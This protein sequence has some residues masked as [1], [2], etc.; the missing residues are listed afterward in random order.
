MVSPDVNVFVKT[1][2]EATLPSDSRAFAVT[3]G[4]RAARTG[5]PAAGCYAEFCTAVKFLL[6]KWRQLSNPDQ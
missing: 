5:T 4:N 2:R 3:A 6:R 1:A